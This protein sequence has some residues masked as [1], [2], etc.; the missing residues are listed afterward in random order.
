VCCL[1]FGLF[2][3]ELSEASSSDD[4]LQHNNQP[5]NAPQPSGLILWQT[6]SSSSPT[7]NISLSSSCGISAVHDG[8]F[9]FF[10]APTTF[11][12]R[13]TTQQLPPSLLRFS[14]RWGVFFSPE[15]GL[16]GVAFSATPV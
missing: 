3:S 16:F 13:V 10:A 2:F 12:L 9:C 11:L 14:R 8:L 7:T 4:P 5:H 1:S 15:Q 6:P